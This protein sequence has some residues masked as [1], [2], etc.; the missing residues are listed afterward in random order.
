MHATKTSEPKAT[1]TTYKDP[2]AGAIEF[3]RQYTEGL[4]RTAALPVIDRLLKG[5]LHDQTDKRIKRCDYCGYYWRDE[6]KRNTK[7]TCSD[8]CKTGIKTMQRRE[9]RARK[10]LL[11]PVKKPRKHRL[12]DDYLWWLE[13]PF[14]IQGYSMLK[15]GWKFEKPTG[16]AAM[17]YI[18][19]KNG[20]YGKGN[21]KKGIK[22][23]NYNGDEGEEF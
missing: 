8:E 6:S 10:E 12:E 3:V 4:T 16:T 5:E 20:I 23:V 1:E 21:R 15:V 2:G 17:D 22:I 13:Y 18:E 14:W 11:N 7:K 19:A 9:Q